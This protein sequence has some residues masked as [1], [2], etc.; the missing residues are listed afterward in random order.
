MRISTE[1]LIWRARNSGE[2]STVEEAIRSY[3]VNPAY[4]NFEENLKGT[5]E[6][7]KL[8][9]M[10][11]LSDDPFKIK[12][13]NIRDIKVLMTVVGGKMSAHIGTI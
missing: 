11:V 4:A 5:I 8:A 7:G 2:R 1:T 12:A 13:E 9:D 10:V 6:E 3:T